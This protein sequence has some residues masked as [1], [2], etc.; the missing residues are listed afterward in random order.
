MK[1]PSHAKIRD[2]AFIGSGVM[3]IAPI[4][5]ERNAFV[6]AGFYYC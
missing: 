4:T 1:Q 2:N 3:L 5:V 6:D